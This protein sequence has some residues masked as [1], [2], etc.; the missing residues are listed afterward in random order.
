[1][2]GLSLFCAAGGP[3]TNMVTEKRSGFNRLTISCA[4][5]IRASVRPSSASKSTSMFDRVHFCF[6]GI[7]AWI[8]LAGSAC[9]RDRSGVCKIQAN[10]AQACSEVS[11]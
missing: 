3:C 7:L 5:V 11:L 6:S 2:F 10:L 8:R 1:M 4:F 9:S